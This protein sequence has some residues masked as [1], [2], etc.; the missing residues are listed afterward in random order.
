M[1]PCIGSGS[2]SLGVRVQWHEEVDLFSLTH[3]SIRFFSPRL[4][5][6]LTVCVYEC[7]CVLSPGEF[8]QSS[9]C[10]SLSRTFFPAC[11]SSSL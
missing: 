6:V 5:R 11:P 8:H 9:L 10:D 4:A 1:A 3:K 2:R 7:V